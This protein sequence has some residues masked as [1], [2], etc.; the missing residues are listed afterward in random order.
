M[1]SL[2][3]KRTKSQAED[4]LQFPCRIIW[5]GDRMP[6][7][8]WIFVDLVVVSALVRLITKEV[9]R[10]VLYPIRLLRLVLQMLQAIRLIPASG[11]DIKRYLA[12]NRVR[13]SQPSKLLPKDTHE[14]LPYL[15]LLIIPLIL[16]PL[17]HTR[18]PPNRT[19]INHPIPELNKRPPLDRHI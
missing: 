18:I 1:P 3:P 6:N 19:N 4:F 7:C 2:R 8:S 16:I 14:R 9:Y 17:L 10:R 5:T 11:E 15:V 12:T 13:Q